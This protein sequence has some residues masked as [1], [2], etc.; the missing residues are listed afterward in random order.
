MLSGECRN[1][2]NGYRGNVAVGGMVIG[3]MS[4]SGEC[5][6]RNHRGNV[7]IGGMVIGGMSQSGEWYRG[8]GHRGNGLSGKCRRPI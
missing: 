6:S 4:Q 5:R 2:G 8:N 7:A 1:R 3:E